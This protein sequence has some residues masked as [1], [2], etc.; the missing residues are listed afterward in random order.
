MP[1]WMQRFRSRGGTWPLAQRHVGWWQV[2]HLLPIAEPFLESMET[3]L[4]SGWHTLAS[5]GKEG[6]SV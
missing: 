6:L 1:G 3:V 4:V 2:K 5:E